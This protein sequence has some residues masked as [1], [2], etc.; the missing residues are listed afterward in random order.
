M[1]FDLRSL[2]L[3]AAFQPKVQDIPTP[4][5]LTAQGA[6][7]DLLRLVG[8]SATERLLLAAAFGEDQALNSALL[9]CAT[10]RYRDSGGQDGRG[11]PVYAMTDAQALA[12][13]DF[14]L[15]NVLSPLVKRFLGLL[16]E[17]AVDDAKNAS[18]ATPSTSGGSASPPDSASPPSESANLDSASMIL[19]NGLPI[20][21]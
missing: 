14:D 15:L 3:G 17:Q 19:S 20:S 21:D 8:M 9:V 2:T 4:D 12:A 16:T 11:T 18:S 7:D 5:A 13:Q 1:T 6:P 10:L